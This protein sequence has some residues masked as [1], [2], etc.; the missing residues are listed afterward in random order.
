MLPPVFVKRSPATNGPARNRPENVVAAVLAT[1]IKVGRVALL[2]EMV[3]GPDNSRAIVPP[4]VTVRLSVVSLVTAIVMGLVTALTPVRG[5]VA[6]KITGE[7]GVLEEG[8]M[9]NLPLPKAS[10]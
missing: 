4:M 2:G 5:V 3:I 9:V 7:A 1:M 6:E 8:L 10:L